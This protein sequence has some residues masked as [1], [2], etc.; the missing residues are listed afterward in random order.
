M[1]LKALISYKNRLIG[2]NQSCSLKLVRE[3]MFTIRK[4]VFNSKKTLHKEKDTY[5]RK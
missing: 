3:L 1:L 4:T 2:L 5:T